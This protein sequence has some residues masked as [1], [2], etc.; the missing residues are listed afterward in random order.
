MVSTAGQTDQQE[1]E[2]PAG[3]A[4]SGAS[5]SALSGSTS[6]SYGVP[7]PIRPMGRVKPPAGMTSWEMHRNQQRLRAQ[8]RRR[9]QTR[10]Q[11]SFLSWNHGWG[12]VIA[13]LVLL[14]VLCVILGILV[15]MSYKILRNPYR[16]KSPLHEGPPGSS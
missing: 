8:R 3:T 10:P 6:T 1:G 4:T 13:L 11:P 12:K 15:V 5:T 9:L 2:R 16:Q 14:I 7:P